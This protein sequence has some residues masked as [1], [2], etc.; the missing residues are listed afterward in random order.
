MMTYAIAIPA[1]FL[2]AFLVS[3]L[4]RRG[5][6]LDHPNNRSSHRQPTPRSGGLGVMAGIAACVTVWTVVGS[7]PP[8]AAVALAVMAAAGLLGLIDDLIAPGPSEKFLSLLAISL[9]AAFSAGPIG[10]IEIGSFALALPFAIGLAG[11]ALWVFV[12]INTVNFADG[13]NGLVALS[14][15]MTGLGLTLVSGEPEGVFLSVALLG[16][17]PWN[18]PSARLFLGDV[19]SLAVGGWF[20]VAGLNAVMGGSAVSVFLVPLL[21]LPLLVDILLTMLGRVRAG[22]KMTHPHRS[23][24]YQLLVRMGLPHWRVAVLYAA[25]SGWCVI[26]ALVAHALGGAWPLTGLVV[27]TLVL[28]LAHSRLRANARAKGLDMG[29]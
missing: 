18:F 21:M 1:G 7:V 14:M 27:M 11:T 16:F 17:L 26:V 23:H 9:A 24:A 6:V 4:V 20:A 28:S 25:L 19:G 10:V 13:S 3:W 5:G 15:A 2:T 29:E 8:H 12:A 22:F